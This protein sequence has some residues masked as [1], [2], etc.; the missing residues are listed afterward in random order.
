[1]HVQC[2]EQTEEGITPPDTDKDDCELSCLDTENK[3]RSSART[4]SALDH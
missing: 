2:P 1:M 4:A 3:L